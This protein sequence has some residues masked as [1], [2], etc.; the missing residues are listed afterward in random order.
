[1]IRTNG[2]FSDIS[3]QCDSPFRNGGA[4]LPT[5]SGSYLTC[6]RLLSRVPTE[7]SHIDSEAE[8]H[9][10][11]HQRRDQPGEPVPGPRRHAGQRH[12][13]EPEPVR[14]QHVQPGDLRRRRQR[15]LRRDPA[16]LDG[17]R[18]H[19]RVRRLELPERRPDKWVI[20]TAPIVNSD[21][22]IGVLLA[23]DRRPEPVA[24]HAPDLQRCAARLAHLGVRR[25]ASRQRPA[26]HDPGHRGLRGE[27]PRVRDL[28]RAA[29][30][31][32]DYRPLGG[33]LC[34]SAASCTNA[35]GD[36]TGTAYGADRTGGSISWIARTSHDHGTL[37]AATSAGRIFVTHNA[38]AL[39]PATVSWHRIDSSTTGSSP[40]RYPSAIY[41]DP[42]N[43]SHAWVA[44]SGY[45]AV[46]PTTPGHVFSVTEGAPAARLGHVHQPERR[47]RL[48]GLPDAVLGRRPA[49]ERHR[50]RRR[51]PHAL[52]GHGLRRPPG[53]QR[54]RR[55]AHDGR[56]CRATRS[57]ISRSSRRAAFRR[58]PA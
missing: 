55:L 54:R 56:A 11:V 25:R 2:A 44:Y 29:P 7:L 8:Q 50:P 16:D 26:G 24:G 45:N 51:H 47:E 22:A 43:A 28:G 57:R 30:A 14:Q 49:G 42:A 10:A 39:D 19:Q 3:S 6:K 21:E 33:P 18:V 27:L 1:M 53:R 34:T 40:T 20:A 58:A 5:T 12:L 13:V 23:A 37:W 15:G 31:C 46:T 38:D 4:P 32:G 35:P 17:E 48:V 36:L 41:V 9:A 52:R